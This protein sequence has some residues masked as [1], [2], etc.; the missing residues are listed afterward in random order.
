MTIFTGLLLGLSTGVF[1]LATC[2][3][4]FLPQVLTEEDKLRGWGVFLKFNFGRLMAYIIFGALFS[5]LG[6][7]IHAQFL[8]KFLK[9][10]SISLSIL[11]ILYGLGLTL[12]RLKWCIWTVKIKF[13]IVSGF[14]LGINVCPPFLLALSQNFQTGQVINGIIYFIMFFI[15][16]TLYLVPIS[17]LGYFST[18]KIIQKGAKLATIAI[19]L[20]LLW[21]SL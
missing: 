20:I 3:P 4:I 14:L 6:S 8:Q 1:C 13:P 9:I 11:L 7:Q 18:V 16:T 12:P 19:G 15:G 17:F 5:W 21:Q 2:V 10:V